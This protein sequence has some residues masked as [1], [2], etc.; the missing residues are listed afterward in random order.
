MEFY[1]FPYIRNVIIPTDEHIFH[2]GGSTTN[3]L[4]T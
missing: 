1:D 3:Q 2:K 4:Y